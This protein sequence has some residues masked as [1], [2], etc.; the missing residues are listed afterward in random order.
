MLCRC[1]DGLFVHRACL[2]HQLTSLPC[3]HRSPYSSSA[4]SC[5]QREEPAAD[6]VP[7]GRACAGGAL[8]RW[9]TPRPQGHCGAA[10]CVQPGCW[11]C[12]GPLLQDWSRCSAPLPSQLLL[13][14]PLSH[15]C[16]RIHPCPAGP[17]LLPSHRIL[18]SPCPLLLLAPGMALGMVTQL[19]ETDDETSVS[20]RQLLAKLDVCM[21]G[22]VAEEL[23]FGAWVEQPAAGACSDR[24]VRMRPC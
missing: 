3:T 11:L 9:R 17:A 5:N 4:R 22:R 12:W 1:L 13:Q 19:P 16:A 23:I 10:W 24:L 2:L 6:C 20:R 15:C 8:Y 7:R 21:G 18:P 14:Y